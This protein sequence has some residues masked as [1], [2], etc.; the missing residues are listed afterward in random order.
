MY[1]F[2]MRDASGKWC[3][4]ALAGGGAPRGKLA[5]ITEL[6]LHCARLSGSPL[7]PRIYGYENHPER[8]SGPRALE[9]VL[10]AAER[11]AE[12]AAAG[13]AGPAT[14]TPREQSV[15]AKPDAGAPD[16]GK[17]HA[18]GEGP[19]EAQCVFLGGMGSVPRLFCRRP[20]G[21]GFGCKNGALSA[22][23]GEVG[24]VVGRLGARV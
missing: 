24:P 22:G 19:R 3:A 21:R 10:K 23:S 1:L 18:G 2:R 13:A 14:S 4:A 11:L 6:L 5:E 8:P 9:A 7:A 12:G 17:R 20:A 16:G 15:G